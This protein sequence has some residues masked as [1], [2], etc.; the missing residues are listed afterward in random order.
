[1]LGYLV[2]LQTPGT[3]TDLTGPGRAG[4]LYLGLVR[5]SRKAQCVQLGAGPKG[6]TDKTLLQPEE[7]KQRVQ[8]AAKKIAQKYFTANER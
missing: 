5:V 1:M 3:L 4:E 6:I 8:V 7:L 2:L